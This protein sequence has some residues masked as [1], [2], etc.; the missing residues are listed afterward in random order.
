MKRLCVPEF[1]FSPSGVP[2]QAFWALAASS[3][4]H[5]WAQPCTAPTWSQ[6]WLFQ[7]FCSNSCPHHAPESLPNTPPF[8]P[9]PAHPSVSSFRRFLPALWPPWKC[10]LAAEPISSSH[11]SWQFWCKKRPKRLH[12]FCIQKILEKKSQIQGAKIPK[13]LRNAKPF[14][15][16]NKNYFKI[17]SDGNLKKSKTIFWAERADEESGISLITKPF[18]SPLFFL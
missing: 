18:S 11:K 7:L 15:S 9:P 3:P 8:S 2:F 10:F 4:C 1:S 6:V 14:S 5:A 17:T 12:L 16:V 13:H